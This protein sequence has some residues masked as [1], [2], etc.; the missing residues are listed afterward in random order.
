M[1]NS[2]KQSYTRKIRLRIRILWLIL[3]LMLVYMVI[4]AELGGGD[5]RI[6]TDFADA[7]GDILFFGGLLYLASRIVHNKKL[8]R[9]RLLLQEQMREE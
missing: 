9:S 7:A 8:L 5:S 1:K 6:V 4:V 3:V 2:N